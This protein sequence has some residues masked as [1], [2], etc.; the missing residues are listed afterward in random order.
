MTGRRRTSSCAALS[1]SLGFAGK[2]RPIAVETNKNPRRGFRRA[3]KSSHGSIASESRHRD[4]S[5]RPVGSWMLRL[6]SV[7]E[8]GNEVGGAW[9]FGRRRIR[10]Q[11]CRRTGRRSTEFGAVVP[12]NRVDF[13]VRGRSTASV[14]RAGRAPDSTCRF[15]LAPTDSR[16]GF[17]TPQRLEAQ[18]DSTPEW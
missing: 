7:L 17:P 18:T 8:C 11:G 15:R 1:R 3:A 12:Q 14:R 5:N 2:Y 10:V 6:S 13:I 4:I 9:V 16:G